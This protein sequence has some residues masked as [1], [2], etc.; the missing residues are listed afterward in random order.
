MDINTEQTLQEIIKNSCR[1]LKEI[2]NT[3]KNLEKSKRNYILFEIERIEKTTD[4]LNLQKAIKTFNIL[5]Q[6]IYESTHN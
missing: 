6:G 1:G 3:D 4:N 2:A 5:L